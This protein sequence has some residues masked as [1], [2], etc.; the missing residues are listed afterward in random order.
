MICVDAFPRKKL[1]LLL[2]EKLQDYVN[3]TEENSFL[4][5]EIGEQALVLVDENYPEAIISK[6]KNII[7]TLPCIE[8][9]I[10]LRILAQL[11]L[12]HYL[13]HDDNLNGEKNEEV[14]LFCKG[15]K[16]K[17]LSSSS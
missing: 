10:L 2:G 5:E 4:I 8:T 9:N 13:I 3:T 12:K 17:K 14:R 15:Y 1:A 11:L 7:V 6:G 16:E